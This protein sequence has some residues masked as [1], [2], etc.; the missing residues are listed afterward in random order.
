MPN[1]S[2][3]RPRP[4]LKVWL[5]QTDGKTIGTIRK[6][7]L[8]CIVRMNGYDCGGKYWAPS[9]KGAAN[10]PEAKRIAKHAFANT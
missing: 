8:G 10:I 3:T 1:L 6:Y 2:I 4:N 5:I 7:P 9:V